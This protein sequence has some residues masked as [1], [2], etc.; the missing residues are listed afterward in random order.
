VTDKIIADLER[1][2]PPWQQPWQAG[3]SAGPVSRPLRAEGKPYRGINVMMLWASAMEKGYESPLWLTYR[4]AEG[5][6]GQVRKGEKGT[7]VVYADRITRT[8]SKYISRELVTAGGA[9]RITIV[10][11]RDDRHPGGIRQRGRP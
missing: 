11:G 6:G 1:G 5:L 3:H 7:L 2:T 8:E 4:Q 9:I 10:T